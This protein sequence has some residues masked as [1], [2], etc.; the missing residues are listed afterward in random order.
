MRYNALLHGSPQAWDR[1][2]KPQGGGS[3]S[4]GQTYYSE[5]NNLY[6]AQ[7]QTAN[8]MLGLGQQYLPNA[9]S[10]YQTATQ[11]IFD[12]AYEA[13]M[14]GNA[15]TT[16]QDQSDASEGAARRSMAS[17]GINPGSGA[18]NATTN[19]NAMSAAALKAGSINS[20]VQNVENTKLGAAQQFYSNLVGMPSN[21]AAVASSASNGFANLG[22]AV[23]NAASQ[24]NAGIANVAAMG[25]GALTAAD[26]GQVNFGKPSRTPL[27]DLSERIAAIKFPSLSVNGVSRV[28]G[29]PTVHALPSVPQV[30]SMPPAPGM[31]YSKGGLVRREDGARKMALGG[32]FAMPPPPQVPLTTPQQPQPSYSPVQVGNGIGKL[33]QGGPSGIANKMQI[34]GGKIATNVGN[35]TGNSPLAAQGLGAQGA[36]AGTDMSP[37]IQAYSAAGDPADAAALAKGAGLNPITG[38][39]PTSE[40]SAMLT[41]SNAGMP[42]AAAATNDALATTTGGDALGALAGGAATADAATTAAAGGASMG[43]GAAAG[44]GAGALTGALGTAAMAIPWLGAAVALGSMFHLF[45]EGGEVEGHGEAVAGRKDYTGGAKVSGP[46]DGTTTGDKVPAWLTD[47]EFVVNAEAATK[48]GNLAKLKKMNNEGLAARRARQGIRRST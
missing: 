33:I 22:N 20:A 16:A 40:Q 23:N 41:A 11:N 25:Y 47:K 35:L 48:P 42:G 1:D 34:Q 44:A 12:P 2:R 37:A 36:G 15:A 32:L 31:M 29:S 38:L 30:Q 3:S 43:L 46:T 8:F 14:A 6:G 5:A 4:P 19:S 21:G 26:G 13:R 9:V 17:Y 45:N 18:W 27:H 39:T 24:Q 7:A 10:Q 28:P